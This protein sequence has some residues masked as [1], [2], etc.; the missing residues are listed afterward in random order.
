MAEP[1]TA[2]RFNF[3]F[4]HSSQITLLKVSANAESQQSQAEALYEQTPHP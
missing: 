2:D 3:P 4:L 1:R